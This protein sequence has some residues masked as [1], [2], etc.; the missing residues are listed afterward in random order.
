MDLQKIIKN[1]GATLT[2]DLKDANLTYGYV[3]SIPNLW[4]R[5]LPLTTDEAIILNAIDEM[6]KV[7]IPN[8]SYVGLWVNDGKIYIDESFHY[9]S[10]GVALA[11][12]KENHEKA[13]YDILEGISIPLTNR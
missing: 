4:T 13:I 6:A 7:I 3:V 5:V 2:K 9:L 11:V 1:G 10:K 8:A 12:A